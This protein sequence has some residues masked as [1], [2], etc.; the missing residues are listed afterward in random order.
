M[1]YDKR[2]LERYDI[3]LIVEYKPLRK[4]ADYGIGITRNLSSEGFCMESQSFEFGIGD[5]LEFKLKHPR[6]ALAVTVAG[7]IIWK[8]QAWY[9][10]IVGIKLQET[11]EDT[12]SKILELMFSVGDMPDKPAVIDEG[13]VSVPETETEE[14]PVT[15]FVMGKIDELMR[16]TSMRVNK[17]MSS[18]DSGPGETSI[19]EG[20]VVSGSKSDRVD[21]ETAEG[22]EPWETV[23][24]SNITAEP[25]SD[26]RIEYAID[27]LQ[28]P[29]TDSV[30][31]DDTV[32]EETESVVHVT[33]SDVHAI[34]RD[35]RKKKKPYIAVTAVVAVII[36]A[37]LPLIY[38]ISNKSPENLNHK[39]PESASSQ[40]IDKK[41]PMLAADDIKKKAP[42]VDTGEIMKVEPVAR[43]QGMFNTAPTVK[44][45]NNFKTEAAPLI[46][47]SEKTIK[48]NPVVRV[49]QT[50]KPGDTRKT[51]LTATSDKPSKSEPIV[52]MEKSQKPELVAETEKTSKPSA[53]DKEKKP[54]MTG[55]ATEGNEAKIPGAV[56]KTEAAPEAGMITKNEKTRE[57][58]SIVKE[59]KI[60]ETEPAAEKVRTSEPEVITKNKETVITEQA[61]TEDKAKKNEPVVQKQ[62][63][64]GIALLVRRQKTKDIQDNSAAE[65]KAANKRWRNIGSNNGI[66]LFIDSENI[67]Y[68]SE[69]I[70]KL[71][72][73]A[74]V[75]ERE[76]TDLLEINCSQKKLRILEERS[77]S[78]PILSAYSSAWRGIN[79][80]HM[81][82]YNSACS[83]NR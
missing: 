58:Q 70:V 2:I 44:D 81:I 69:D 1:L 20:P 19:K 30:S 82:I 37:A 28:R 17:D 49:E 4:T 24:K 74:S 67:S 57:T 31:D 12:K 72:I 22:V 48:M 65:S 14:K 45:E 41:Q 32:T 42:P 11:D 63:F 56:I 53:V 26:I 61:V 8:K 16:D 40:D 27:E 68:P 55:Q 46:A 34:K 62:E 10:Y 54:P 75:K 64:P 18:T 5:S 15:R 52:M 35:R 6:T 47:K 29:E 66:P 59:E 9:K 51:E 60:P 78:N 76:Y 23:E 80:D 79:P 36:M 21:Y 33:H 3:F 73:K 77:G 25:L 38:G 39:P 83:N 43:N 13:P 71:L 7:E 50:K